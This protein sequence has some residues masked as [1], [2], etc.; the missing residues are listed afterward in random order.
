[1]TCTFSALK[2]PSSGIEAAIGRHWLRSDGEAHTGVEP[3]RGLVMVRRP[4]TAILLAAD[5]KEAER[6]AL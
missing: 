1:M 5:R 4:P 3:R 6:S 2:P